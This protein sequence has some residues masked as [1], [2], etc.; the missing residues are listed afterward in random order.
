MRT[1]FPESEA[2]R[3]GVR[4]LARYKGTIRMPK[5]G[6]GSNKRTAHRLKN[7]CNM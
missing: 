3:Y 4:D 1:V 5:I 6:Y 2:M 7:G